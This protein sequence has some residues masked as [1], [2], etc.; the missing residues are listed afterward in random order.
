MSPR[1]DGDWA[2]PSLSLSRSLQGCYV[3]THANATRRDANDRQCAVY[4]E[5]YMLNFLSF[6]F[7]AAGRKHTCRLAAW[8]HSSWANLVMRPLKKA[9]LS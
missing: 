8:G 1:D 5:P 3:S 9:A 7:F 2:S 4:V 6:L